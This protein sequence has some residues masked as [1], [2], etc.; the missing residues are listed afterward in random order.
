MKFNKI[1]DQK[2][3]R[4]IKRSAGGSTIKHQAKPAAGDAKASPKVNLKQNPKSKSDPTKPNAAN[5][6]NQSKVIKKKRFFKQKQ[7]KQV[8]DA[9]IKTKV[10]IPQSGEEV[11]ANWQQMADLIRNENAKKAKP[12]SSSSK[13]TSDKP[14][15]TKSKGGKPTISDKGKME[16]QQQRLAKD[17]ELAKKERFKLKRKLKREHAK[18][19]IRKK[20]ASNRPDDKQKRPD[21]KPKEP[22][23]SNSTE[24]PNDLWFEVDQIY[25]DKALNPGLPAQPIK[26]GDLVKQHASTGLTKAIGIDCEMVGVGP[27][28]VSALARISMVNQFGHTVYDKFVKPDEPITDFRTFVS[29]IR[30][31]DLKDGLPI[32]IARSEVEQIIRGRLLVGHA[33]RNDLA[34]LGIRH[35]PAFV[36][37]TSVYFKQ[38]FNGKVPSLKRLSETLLNVKVQTGEHSSVEDAKAT[39][40]L[41]T[42]YKKDWEASLS[43]NNK[44]RQST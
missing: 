19:K 5:Q 13:P 16:G 15:K 17:P 39:M 29:G 23:S 6:T 14:K 26:D 20:N 37:D 34:A 9:A 7:K 36:R 43:K 27:R 30:P 32:D 2:S 22:K 24:K 33:I 28:K 18:L 8:P 4:P 42:L 11:S 3:K 31:V 21:G 44:K 1:K 35:P 10:C 12:I 25:L 41:Y 40:R 38:M